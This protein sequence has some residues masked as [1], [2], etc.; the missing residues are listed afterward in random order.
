MFFYF[1]REKQETTEDS[2]KPSAYTYQSSIADMLKN[3]DDIDGHSYPSNLDELAEKVAQKVATLIKSNGAEKSHQ[4]HEDPQSSKVISRATNLEE[5][6]EEFPDVEVLGGKSCRILCCQTCYNFLSDAGSIIRRPTG[7]GSGTLA[8]GLQ[9]DEN[10]FA[11]LQ[12]GH[13]QK[14]YHQKASLLEHLATSTHKK[15]VANLGVVSR[16]INR[17]QKVV[18]NQLRTALGIVKTKSA[19]LQ[20][21]SRI[22]EL[23]AA[24]ADIG[25]FGHSRKLFPD[26]IAVACAYIDKKSM[27]FLASPLPSTGLPPHFYVT[28]DKSTNLRKQNQISLVCP[29]VNG[30]R[31]GIPMHLHQVYKTSDGGGGKNDVLAEAILQDIAKHV[32]IKGDSLIQM[33]GK[34]VDGQYINDKFIPAM[35]APILD[36]LR[37]NNADHENVVADL[38]WWPCQWEVQV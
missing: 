38:F 11:E 30:T 34:V 27:E 9:L 3:P 10:T 6:C 2:I 12:Q 22:A 14:W 37:K 23:Y 17:E 8:L 32:G 5:F 20:Y 25:D 36:L 13:C 16:R 24:G 21:E 4:K 35:N 15:A 29:V 33:Q 18:K 7:S 26:M 1:L 31:Q 28:A 19:A